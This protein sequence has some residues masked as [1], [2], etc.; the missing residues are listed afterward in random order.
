MQYYSVSGQ[1]IVDHDHRNAVASDLS[2]EQVIDFVVEPSKAVDGTVAPRLTR[3]IEDDIQKN[4]LDPSAVQLPN[5]S[6]AL[7]AVSMESRWRQS[8][9][10]PSDLPSSGFAPATFTRTAT[11]RSR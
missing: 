3:M 8:K 9:R 10:P 7:G 11:L 1:Q 4:D 2:P 6:G 5:G